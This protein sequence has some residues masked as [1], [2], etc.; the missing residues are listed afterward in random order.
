MTF[1]GGTRP[2]EKKKKAGKSGR[3][4]IEAGYGKVERVEGMRV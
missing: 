1:S 2:P 3:Q 4:E